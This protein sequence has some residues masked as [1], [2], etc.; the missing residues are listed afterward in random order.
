[1]GGNGGKTKR[2]ELL[3]NNG[4]KRRNIGREILTSEGC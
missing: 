4:S 2:V 3:E 1:M